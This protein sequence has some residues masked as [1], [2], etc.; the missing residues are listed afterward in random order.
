MNSTLHA[1]TSGDQAG[2]Q[3]TPLMNYQS[4]L[5]LTNEHRERLK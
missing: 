5:A 2:V 4:D 3:V 1:K